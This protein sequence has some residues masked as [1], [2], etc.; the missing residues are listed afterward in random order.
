METKYRINA[1]IFLWITIAAA[2]AIANYGKP[3]DAGGV[4]LTLILGMS[5]GEVSKLIANIGTRSE[6]EKAK[7]ENRIE[8]MLDTLSDDEMTDLRRRLSNGV[9]SGDLV[10]LEDVLADDGELSLQHR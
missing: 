1:I 6:D 4:V 5:G 2:V 7:R 8:A 9:D 10:A 3:I